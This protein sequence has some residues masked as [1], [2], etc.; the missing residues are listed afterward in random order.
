MIGGGFDPEEFSAE[1]ADAI[2]AARFGREWED[3]GPE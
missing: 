1:A 2:V 3:T